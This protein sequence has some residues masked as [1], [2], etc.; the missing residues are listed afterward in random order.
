M[1]WWMMTCPPNHSSGCL[2]FVRGILINHLLFCSL[3]NNILS[4]LHLFWFKLW[5]INIERMINRKNFPQIDYIIL[6]IDMGYNILVVKRD[7]NT[8]I[9]KCVGY[10]LFLFSLP[11]THQCWE[12]SP[13][14]S[15]AIFLLYS[16]SIF[17]KI[18]RIW[19]RF[20]SESQK[21]ALF[22]V[23]ICLKDH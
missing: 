1:W 7:K 6:S 18:F 21:K 3:S 5:T 14:S 22:D 8:N 4:F 13:S 9:D 20:S 23:N 2:L 10:L 11:M 16:D 15:N 17:R 19:I 12:F